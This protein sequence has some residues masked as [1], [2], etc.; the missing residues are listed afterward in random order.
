M[1]SSAAKIKLETIDYWIRWLSNSFASGEWDSHF[2][3]RGFDFQGTVPYEEDPDP[4]R[5][6][7]PATLSS[8]PIE[9]QVSQYGEEH[10]VPVY[11]LGDLSRSMS[12]GT[13][14]TK[15]DRL[16][17]ITALLAFSATRTKDPFRFIGFTDKAELDFLR[18]GDKLTP[19]LLAEEILRFRSLA[20]GSGGLAQATAQIPLQPRALVIVISDF[21][22]GLLK[23]EE[24]IG[25]LGLRHDVLPIV[26]WDKRDRAL[27]RGFGVLH[28][29]DLETDR[30]RHVFLWGPTREA[31]ERNIARLRQQI[32]ELFRRHTVEPVFFDEMGETDVGTLRDTFLAR[33]FGAS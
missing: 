17:L 10:D 33:R 24:A 12:F 16:A 27:P 2:L 29:A 18:S 8:F 4:A 13:E 22:D 20:K 21:F 3:G 11:V 32:I 19:L 25:P 28:L 6:N 31:H 1:A 14:W 7:W 23:T 30:G 15:Q 5:V 9:I 26:L